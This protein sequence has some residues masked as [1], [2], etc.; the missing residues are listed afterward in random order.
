[1]WR[2][3]P[4]SCF[5]GPISQKNSTPSSMI[6]RHVSSHWLEAVRPCTIPS[7]MVMTG[8]PGSHLSPVCEEYSVMSGDRSFS[9]F[10]IS[11]RYFFRGSS[12]GCMS[13]V[14]KAALQPF[15]SDIFCAPRSFASALA[16]SM[17][18][19]VP[20]SAKPHG[21]SLF[22]I[23]QMPL[24]LATTSSHRASISSSLSPTTDSI[25]CGS[26]PSASTAAFMTS[27]RTLASLTPSSKLKQPAVHRAAS[28][29]QDTPAAAAASAAL[30]P[31]W[32]FSHSRPHMAATK[33]AGWQTSRL[34]SFSSGPTSVM[35]KRSYPS[36]SLAFW[37][38]GQ[39]FSC[40]SAHPSIPSLCEP[41][42]G[43]SSAKDGGRSLSMFFT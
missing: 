13:S 22:A 7:A 17:A 32:S 11:I 43:K 8:V 33:T 5:I 27:P 25:F 20:D 35:S 28:S 10:I 6:H 21:K 3:I 26:A 2:I 4:F 37:I 30:L 15:S 18:A 41:W 39:A 31:S 23:L 14:W 29:P 19:A 1:M 16:E 9:A 12:A 34:F 24:W 38:I 36:T 42:P 40:S